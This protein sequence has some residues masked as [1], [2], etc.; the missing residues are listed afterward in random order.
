MKKSIIFSL[1]ICSSLLSHGQLSIGFSAGSNLSSMSIYLRDRNTFR[2]NPTFGYN[3]NIITE[4]KFNPNISLWSGLSITQKGFNQHIKYFYM[5][6]LDTTANITSKLNY[7]ELP[8]YLKFTTNLNQIDLFYGFG[9]Y[10]SYGIQGKI[11][12]EINGRSDLTISEKMKWDKVYDYSDLVNYYAYANLKR[13][14]FGVGTM[15]GMEYKNFMV[16]ASYRYG[17]HNLM[18]EYYQD[19]KMSNSSLSI[20]VGYSFSSL[21]APKQKEIK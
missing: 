6:G 12:T 15:L 14:D 21:F 11:T 5:P 2:I 9:P 17:L 7:L 4:Y 20:S 13:F 3:V 19:E 18:W 8:L 1:I 10:V 16:I